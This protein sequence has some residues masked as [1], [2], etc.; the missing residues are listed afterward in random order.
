MRQILLQICHLRVHL[1]VKT[2]LFS[3]KCRSDQKIL[4]PNLIA[5]RLH[6]IMP[7]RHPPSW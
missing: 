5:W 2:V 3:A 7:M 4:N 1:G 6:K